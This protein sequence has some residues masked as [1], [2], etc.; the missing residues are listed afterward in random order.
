MSKSEASNDRCSEFVSEAIRPAG[1]GFDTS[2][3]GRGEPGLPNAF[4]WRDRTYTIESCVARWKESQR[5]GGPADGQIYLRRHCYRLRMND[6]TEWEVYFTRQPSSTGSAR[7]RWFL[8]SVVH[9][10]DSG[11]PA[12]R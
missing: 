1:G 10:N 4:V 12:P 5:T 6:G 8:L 3:M 11:T 2:A 7:T 9:Q